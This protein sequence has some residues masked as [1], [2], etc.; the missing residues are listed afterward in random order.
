MVVK[1]SQHLNSKYV[2]DY[3]SQKVVPKPEEQDIADKIMSALL[4]GL[5]IPAFL[6]SPFGLYALVHG[7]VRYYF[8][9]S[10]FN[11][12]VKRLQRRGYVA[13]TKTEKGWLVRLLSKGGVRVKQIMFER[14]TLPKEK[15]WDGRWRLFSFDIPEEYKNARNSLRFKLKSLG[16][17]NIQRSLFA[18]P[19]ECKQ[20]LRLVVEH[21]KVEKYTLFAEVVEIDVDQE[22][23][24]FF[25]L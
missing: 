4:L 16:C 9:K 7:A 20:E 21:Y 17:Y 14:L 22:L 8:R 23:R 11:R 13:L 24:K 1:K 6:T 25:G 10:D 12:E 2:W 15:H 3:R 19:Y 18:Y 5:A